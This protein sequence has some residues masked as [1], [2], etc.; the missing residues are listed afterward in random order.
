M[1][2]RARLILFFVLL[3]VVPLVAVG[4]FESVR[5]VRTLHALLA[6]Q[7]SAITERV[8]AGISDPHFSKSAPLP[9][10]ETDC[11]G[12]GQCPMP[13][14]RVARKPLSLTRT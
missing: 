1:Q 9:A 10:T 6:A 14:A 3:A 7:D 8:A 13:V 5:S 11:H 12:R 4:V 2:L